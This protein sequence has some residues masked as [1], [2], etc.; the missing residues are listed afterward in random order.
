M[1]HDR[2]YHEHHAEEARAAKDEPAVYIGMPLGERTIARAVKS[3]E[4]SLTFAQEFRP[5]DV[6][7]VLA[8][9]AARQSEG[10]S[11]KLVGWWNG[12]TPGYDGQGDW[13]IRWG[14]DAEN[15]RHDIP[16]YDGLNPIH[17]QQPA[18][19]IDLTYI[20][21]LAKNWRKCLMRPGMGWREAVSNCADELDVA[22]ALIDNQSDA[23]PEVKS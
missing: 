17:Y 8:A 6:R 4:Q 15:S 21:E 11:G 12:I 18:Q 9:L 7:I 14:A 2:H 16:L 1:T 5:E 13:S 10:A 19:G 23:A 3:L 20:R 22:L